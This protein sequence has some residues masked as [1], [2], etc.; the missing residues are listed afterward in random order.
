MDKHIKKSE[1]DFIGYYAEATK[2]LSSMKANDPTFAL[3]YDV[4]TALSDLLENKA[5][6][7]VRL[8]AAYDAKDKD[9]LASLAAEC[10]VILRK[11]N[12]LIDAHRR[13]W[14]EYNKPF[15]WEVHDIRYGGLVY[16]FTTAKQRI[17]QYL[18]GEITAIEELEAE[19]LHLDGSRDTDKEAFPRS[20]IWFS[21]STVATAS[22]I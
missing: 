15:G 1:K 11:L 21:Y 10:D 5:D 20:F 14:M 17:E 9:A 2:K 7:G 22:R 6:Y 19:R 4:I 8:K 13:S 12:V 18:K 16:R 3:S